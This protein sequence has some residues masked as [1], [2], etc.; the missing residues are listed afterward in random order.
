MGV[1][2]QR[3]RQ[4]AWD[5]YHVLLRELIFGVKLGDRGRRH[6]VELANLGRAL[7]HLN[8]VLVVRNLVR[9]GG[10]DAHA[11]EGAGLVTLGTLLEAGDGALAALGVLDLRYDRSPA[12]V[13]REER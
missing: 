3:L 6:A 8:R 5:T 9:H 2:L 4:W 13:K 7:E 1:S 10:D 12:C 11:A